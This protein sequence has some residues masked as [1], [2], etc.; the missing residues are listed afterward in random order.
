MATVFRRTPSDT[1]SRDSA[2]GPRF[3]FFALV[4]VALMVLDQRGGWIDDARFYLQSATQPFLVVMN[5]PR[6][7]VS[8]FGE[9]FET[10]E[11]LRAEIAGL[12]T[13]ER[14]LSL[15]Q[16]RLEAL[17][18]ENA[19]L[20][21]LKAAMPPL[22]TRQQVAEVVSLELNP[23]RQ[24]LLVNKG[25]QDDIFDGQAV[26]DARGLLGQVSRV[27]PWS[28]EIIL[29][30]DPEHAVPVQLA[31][32]GLRS[33]AVGA[34]NSGELLLPYLP[35]NSDVKAGDLLVTSG[36][37][38]VYPAGYPVAVVTG[39]KRDPVMLLAQVR[40]RPL[41]T[42]ERDREVMLVWFDASHP[43]APVEKKATELPQVTLGA[44]TEPDA[45]AA[46]DTAATDNA[47]PDPART[48][49]PDTKDTP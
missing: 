23:L 10:R 39:I 33:I 30:T 35:V 12:R 40:A 1:S 2:P 11:S 32:N 22:V 17:E 37:G 41:A 19:Q 46:A 29:V 38:G 21:A 16:L 27:G 25:R 45:E 18:H 28:A 31:R 34:G 20:R 14:E 47:A 7:A 8:W 48:P 6:S 13:R 26:L 24:R 5:S 3:A 36:L 9:L 43:A 4:S 42:L 49:G 44:P 15:S